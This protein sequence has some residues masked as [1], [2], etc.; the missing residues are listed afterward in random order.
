[1]IYVGRLEQFWRE[2][3]APFGTDLGNAFLVYNP[4]MSIWMFNHVT[5]VNVSENE[6]KS[7]LNR[8]IE[9]YLSRDFPNVCFRISPLTHP[10]SFTSFLEDQ[11]F[12]RKVDTSVMVLKEKKV[13][14]L[15]PDVI[16]KEISESEKDEFV[17]L[18]LT[19]FEMS[20]ELKEGFCRMFLKMMRRGDKFHL[21]FVEDK[22]VGIYFLSSFNRTGGIFSVG[23]LNEYRRRGIG[24]TLVSHAIMT[25]I[26]EGNNLHTLQ[27]K[28]GGNAERLYK[29][30]GFEIDH[31]VSFYLKEFK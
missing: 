11:G 25:S 7:L 15:N 19:T 29:T 2:M 6:V 3:F 8:V 12:E 28:K 18:F 20:I 14:N 10:K 4:D 23:T 5:C 26:N 1:M 13:H 30:L 22:P 17:E 21:A 27:A 24:T 16:I 9:Y 31:V